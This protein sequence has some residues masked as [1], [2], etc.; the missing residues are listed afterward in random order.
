MIMLR[1]VSLKAKI[2]IVI[3]ILLILTFVGTFSIV[4]IKLYNSSMFQAETLAEELSRSYAVEIGGH[5]EV[6]ETIANTLNNAINNQM[7]SGFKDRNTII[8]ME[9]DELNMHPEIYGITAAFEPNAFDGKDS[10]YA[11]QAQYGENGL[12]IPYVTRSNNSFHVEPAYNSRTNMTWYNEP[13]KTKRTFVTEPTVYKVNGKDVAMVSLVVPILDQSKNFIGVISIDYKLET[14][15]KI[16]QGM[17]PMGGF[18]QLISQDGVYIANGANSKLIMNNAKKSSQDWVNI[19]NQTSKGKQVQM[20][21]KSLSTGQNVLRAAYPINIDGSDVKWT[22]CS[23]IPLEN[24]LKDFYIQLKQIILIAIIIL[25]IVI[26]AIIFIVNYMTKGLKYAETQLDLLAQGDLTKEIDVKYFKSEDEIGEMINSMWRMQESIKSIIKKVKESSFIVSDLINNVETNINGLNLRI[27]DISTTTEE[28]SA[29]MEE[30]ASFSEEMSAAAINIKKAVEH[31][32]LKAERGLKSAKKINIRADKLKSS[33]IQSQQEAYNI[34]TSIN[35]KLKL[36][37][38]K[39]KAVDQIGSLTEGILE[40]TSQTN[41]LALNASIEAARAGESG[42]GFA[43]VADEI[44]KLAESSENIVIKIQNI[45]KIVMESVDSL[46][47]SSKDVL[48]FIENK[49]ITDYDKL[50]D[51]GERYSKDAFIVQK[52]VNDFSETSEELLASIYNIVKSIEEVAAAASEGAEGT[53]NIAQGTTSIVE[54]SGT[55]IKQA[56]QS[57]VSAEKLLEMISAFKV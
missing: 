28:L 12:F 45:T 54:L 38:E 39:S 21:G 6:I 34:S 8:D 3:G 33:A 35:K 10:L 55:V 13:K 52:L 27:G 11:G 49:I 2:S 16:V 57:K 44:R 41:L 15:Q 9:K 23:D 20:F 17:K 29:G 24:I 48:E 43:V 36:A 32:A 25:I 22:F 50:V 56:S 37:L 31:I 51:T 47:D 7:K 46:K 14:F 26:I 40:V 18:A 4:L 5:L 1:K 53:T 19:I 42:K 30:T